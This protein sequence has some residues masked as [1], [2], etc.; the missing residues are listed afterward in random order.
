M[1]DI[2]VSTITSPETFRNALATVIGA[3]TARGVDV[4]G[5]WEF[6]TRGSTLEWD[7]KISEVDRSPD[8]DRK[9]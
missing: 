9:G 5:A 4:R 7:I 3:A 2:S 6:E 8:A 1:T